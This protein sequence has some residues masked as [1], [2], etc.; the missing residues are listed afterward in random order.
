VA[1]EDEGTRLGLPEVKL[2]IH[3]G[4]GGTVRLPPLVGDLT[5]LNLM[6]TGRT[7]AE[8]AALFRGAEIIVAAHGAAL[9]NLV[10]CAPGTTLVE[11]H[12]PRYTL[13]LYWRLA[14]RLG[15]RYAAVQGLAVPAETGKIPRLADMMIDAPASTALVRR[16]LEQRP[17]LP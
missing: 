15:L 9:A 4:F 10:F 5:A 17:T 8:Q 6:L 11:L 1:R 12:Y 16:A 14:R 13:G 7:V 3:P 2:G